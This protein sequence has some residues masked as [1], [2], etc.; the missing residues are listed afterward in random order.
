MVQ[1]R[2]SATRVV[3]TLESC[4]GTRAKQ[5]AKS[6]TQ[7]AQPHGGPVLVRHLH[8]RMQS[9][10]GVGVPAAT[11]DFRMSDKAQVVKPTFWQK[12][13]PA[14]QCRVWPVA[15]CHKHEGQGQLG[16]GNDRATGGQF[17]LWPQAPISEDQDQVELTGA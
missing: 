8:E 14:L 4:S 6:G 7:E 3:K 5:V 12:V 9:Q 2:A 10:C 13:V 16:A 11:N 15:Q 1:N 17:L